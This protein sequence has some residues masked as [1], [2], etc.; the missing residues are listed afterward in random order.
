MVEPADLELAATWAEEHGAPF[1]PAILPRLGVVAVDEDGPVA[2][3]WLHM[4]NSVG[5]CWPEMPVSKP[6]LGVQ[7]ARHAFAAIMGFL[8][9][10]A[11]RLDYGVMICHTNPAIARILKRL[12]FEEASAGWVKLYK[13][14]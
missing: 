6:G 1:V 8:E 12:G 11:R 7:A 3:C 4:D 10:E 5:V 9:E 2:M 13:K 14:L